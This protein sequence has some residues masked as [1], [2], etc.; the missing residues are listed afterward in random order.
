M[1]S[2]YNAQGMDLARIIHEAELMKQDIEN[3][4]FYDSHLGDWH[5]LLNVTREIHEAVQRKVMT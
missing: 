3:Q 4:R 1:A 5:T 2:D